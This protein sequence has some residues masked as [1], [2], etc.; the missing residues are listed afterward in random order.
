MD[1]AET[2]ATLGIVRRQTK[3]EKTQHNTEK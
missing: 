2:Q 3:E 1:N